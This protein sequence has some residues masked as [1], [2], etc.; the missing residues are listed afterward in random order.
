MFFQKEFSRCHILTY[1]ESL[2][3]YVGFEFAERPQFHATIPC[4]HPEA[5][6]ANILGFKHLSN[7]LNSA[8]YS[9]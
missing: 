7:C 5:N 8:K 6:L 2:C 9:P 4:V 3:F 1:I